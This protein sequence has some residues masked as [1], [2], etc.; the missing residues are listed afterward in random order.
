[1]KKILWAVSCISLIGTAIVLQFLPDRVPMH[2]DFS[3]NIDRWGSKY[4][5]FLIP[6][7]ILLFAVFWHFFISHFEK[8]ADEVFD[9]KAAAEARSNAKV[10]SIVSV[11]MAG[12]FTVMQGFSLYGA[13]REAAANATKQAVDIGKVSVILTGVIM[14]VLG[15]IMTKTRNNRLVGFRIKWSMYNDT[16]WRKSNRFSA[17]A[18]MIAGLLTVVIGAVMKNSYAATMTSLGLILLATIVSSIYAYKVYVQE[19]A[20]EEKYDGTN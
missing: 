12:M 3:G 1:M 6:A 13:Y 11:V 10:L 19:K 17:Y 18:I 20:S 5:E 16:T 15:N 9:E 8:K 7:I 2:Y 4:E 14:I